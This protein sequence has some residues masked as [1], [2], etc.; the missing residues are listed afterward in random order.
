[1]QGYQPDRIVD[2]LRKFTL[3]NLFAGPLLGTHFPAQDC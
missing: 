2:N 3:T 1:M